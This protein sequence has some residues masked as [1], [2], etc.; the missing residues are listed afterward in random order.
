ML[1]VGELLGA[2]LKK[3]KLAKNVLTSEMLT[4]FKDLQQL[5]VD[6]AILYLASKFD[7]MEEF[8]K[9]LLALGLLEATSSSDSKMDPLESSLF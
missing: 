4:K 5:L 1:E 6:I 8:T 2:V 3:E 7:I 9:I